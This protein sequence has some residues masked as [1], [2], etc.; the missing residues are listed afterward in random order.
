MRLIRAFGVL[1]A[2]SLLATSAVAGHH[3]GSF[4]WSTKSA[5]AIGDR[6]RRPPGKDP[7]SASRAGT[8][9]CIASAGCGFN[10]SETRHIG[11][12]QSPG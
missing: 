5:E 12:R 3:E 10:D 6:T 11:H 8:P 9:S 2:S 4:K 7:G 1:A